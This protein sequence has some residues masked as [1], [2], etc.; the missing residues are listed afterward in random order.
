MRLCHLI[1]MP[2]HVEHQPSPARTVTLA[3]LEESMAAKRDEVA[4]FEALA[5]ASRRKLDEMEAARRFL[6]GEAQQVASA[7]L[8]EAQ[9]AALADEMPTTTVGT[10]S[11]AKTP[12]PKI[13]HQ[14]QALGA[15]AKN[16]GEWHRA[17][18]IIDGAVAL[19]PGQKRIERTSISPLLTKMRKAKPEPLVEHQE[20]ERRWRI[21]DAG[22]RHVADSEIGKR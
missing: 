7:D 9:E 14:D 3:E 11:L 4:R 13:K 5:E 1:A 20:K 15:L 21:T 2:N 19:F 8:T 17:I 12:V 16:P 22:L 6:F 18:D 10:V